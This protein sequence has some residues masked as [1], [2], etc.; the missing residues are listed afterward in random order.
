ME[1][2][3]YF[4]DWDKTGESQHWVD[5]ISMME[6]KIAQWVLDREP[7]CRHYD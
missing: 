6:H 5:G 7:G 4:G 1:F 3:G 2:D